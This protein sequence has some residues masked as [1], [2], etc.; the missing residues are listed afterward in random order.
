MEEEDREKVE[1]NCTIYK[2][3]IIR[4]VELRLKRQIDISL[5]TRSING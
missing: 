5:G 4:N 2:Y 3:L 1:K